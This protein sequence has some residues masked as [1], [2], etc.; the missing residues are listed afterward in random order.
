MCLC[1]YAC[2]P[3]V[4]VCTLYMPAAP[5]LLFSTK[6]GHSYPPTSRRDVSLPFWSWPNQPISA[7]NSLRAPP[8]PSPPP[9]C[10]VFPRRDVSLP[11][12][13]HHWPD[14]C[15]H[16]CHP[17]VYQIWLFLLNDVLHQQRM[18]NPVWVPDRY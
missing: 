9:L 15:T 4:H 6:A 11:F 16:W 18:G 3:T 12:W 2:H 7:S 8:P 14:E 1:P 13:N 10:P 17:S 5:L